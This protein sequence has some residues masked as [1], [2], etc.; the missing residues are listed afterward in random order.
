M[1]DTETNLYN[2]YSVGPIGI[3]IY[4]QHLRVLPMT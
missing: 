4:I 1:S 3:T 2:L